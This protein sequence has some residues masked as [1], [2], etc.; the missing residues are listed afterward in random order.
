MGERNDDAERSGVPDDRLTKLRDKIDSLDAQILALLNE[1]GRT[2][3]EIGALKEGNRQAIYAP[4]RERQVLTRLSELNRGGVYPDGSVRAIFGEIISASRALETPMRVAY[5]GP[6]ASFCHLAARQKLGASADFL[7][8]PTQR[9]IFREVELRRCD[10]GVVPVENSTM[11]IVVD[12]LDLFAS[13][14]LKICGEI[15]LP[16]THNLLSKSKLED[17]KRVYS[18]QQAL[19]QCRGWLREHLPG[20]EQIALSSTSEAARRCVS[21]VD[22]A[23]ISSAFAAETYGLDILQDH[24][25]DLAENVTRFLIIGHHCAEPTGEDKTTLR[26]MLRHEPGALVRVLERFREGGFNV[27]SIQSRPSRVKTWEYVFFAEVVGH[28]DR[29]PL[30][31]ALVEIQSVCTSVD[32]LGSY[33]RG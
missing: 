13:S 4:H 10:Y 16:V 31:D 8:Q 22:A 1:R 12:S 32:V 11:G 17:V 19:S 25:E 9:E 18:H 6:E 30:K 5:L 26:F 29:Q 27:T 21:E 24:V 2:A 7:P 28:A 15:L 33:Q 3:Q 14:P 23:A 20:I